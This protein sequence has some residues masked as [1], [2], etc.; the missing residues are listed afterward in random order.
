MRGSAQ[1]GTLPAVTPRKGTQPPPSP[2]QCRWAL[3]PSVPTHTLGACGARRELCF[4]PFSERW[5]GCEDLS[6]SSWPT[7]TPTPTSKRLP[8]ETSSLYVQEMGCTGR[9]PAPKSTGHDGPPG[10]RPFPL[11]RACLQPVGPHQL[12]RSPDYLAAAWLPSS[13]WAIAETP[14]DQQ[15][16]QRGGQELHLS[17]PTPSS[18]RSAGPPGSPAAL[19]LGPSHVLSCKPRGSR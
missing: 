7:P 17:C 11:S 9:G 14:G 13:G 16:G 19:G 1:S 6:V 2:T 10:S 8:T 3:R 15:M 18:P 5:P 4:T 12:V